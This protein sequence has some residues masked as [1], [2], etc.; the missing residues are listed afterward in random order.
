[1]FIFISKLIH[2]YFLQLTADF[3]LARIFQSPLRP[4]SDNG[5]VVTI[6]YRAPELLLGAKHYT[7]AVDIWAIGCIFAELITTKPLFPGKEKDPQNP[8]LFQTDQVDK[9]FQLLGYCLIIPLAV[10]S[11]VNSPSPSS[12]PFPSLQRKPT[13]EIWPDVVGLPEWP[14]IQTDFKRFRL[15][16]F[17]LGCPANQ[18]T[19]K[20]TYL[21]N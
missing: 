21:L 18:L 15:V 2:M 13:P 19:A 1:M 9:I 11:L 4:L 8:N 20:I 17:H 7:R 6:W 14:R 5:V 10:H 16:A 12:S 3:G